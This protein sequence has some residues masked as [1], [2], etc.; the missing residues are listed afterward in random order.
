[1][2]S[3]ISLAQRQLLQLPNAIQD[4]SDS[5]LL[6][7]SPKD[8]VD[9]HNAHPLRFKESPKIKIPATPE[10]IKIFLEDVGL[11][12]CKYDKFKQAKGR[13]IDHS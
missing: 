13:V 8:S 12:F 5:P 6:H 7:H 9:V 2:N 1:M 4:Q 11:H 3:C 10:S